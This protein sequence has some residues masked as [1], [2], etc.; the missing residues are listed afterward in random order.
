MSTSLPTLTPPTP[1]TI[2]ATQF[3][4]LLSLYP[5]AVERAYQQNPRLKGGKK[6]ADALADDRWRYEELPG[7][8]SGR[9]ADAGKGGGNE[10][11]AW[12]EKGELERLVGWKM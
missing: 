2:T 8:I 4:Y 1:A 3:I 12:L 11:G 6:L 10:R 9:R 5:S 7:I